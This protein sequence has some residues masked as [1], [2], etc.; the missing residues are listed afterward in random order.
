MNVVAGDKLVPQLVLP[1]GAYAGPQ[2]E[3][4]DLVERCGRRE[5]RR[6]GVRSEDDSVR[7]DENRLCTMPKVTSSSRAMT[8]G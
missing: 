7:P 5:Q 2:L 4:V 6:F 8:I 3:R 1:G